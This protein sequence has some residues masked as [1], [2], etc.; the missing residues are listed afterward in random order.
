MIDSRKKFKKKLI[1]QKTKRN[2]L[3]FISQKRTPLKEDT[4]EEL[5]SN[6]ILRSDE[7]IT[8]YRGLLF[9][10]YQ[11]PH[12]K[13]ADTYYYKSDRP[14]SW[15]KDIKI[16]ER[17]AKYGYLNTNSSLI[18]SFI[19]SMRDGQIDGDLGLI[20]SYT[21]NPKDIL[22]DIE[23]IPNKFNTDY[24]YEKEVIVN[25]VSVETKVEKIFTKTATYNSYEEF[26]N[27]KVENNYN[28][29]VEYFKN[30]LKTIPKKEIIRRY[31]EYKEDVSVKYI[32]SLFNSDLKDFAKKTYAKY[33]ELNKNKPELKSPDF[34]ESDR[35]KNL[36]SDLKS[37]YR[38]V[39]EFDNVNDIIK[40]YYRRTLYAYQKELK[41]KDYDEDFLTNYRYYVHIMGH[42]YYRMV[43]LIS[44]IEELNV[45][46]PDQVKIDGRTIKI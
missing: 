23:K 44:I 39:R 4:I 42:S 2:L 34:S 14:T 25:A 18:A 31:N 11:A 17:F 27:R 22:V 8:L 26:K 12:I 46:K 41:M 32:K 15:T 6:P 40:P 10:E 38:Y 33:V 9:N 43:N 7:S 45:E 19:T 5:Q 35:V 36:Y 24:E 30:F 16:A 28:E 37:L 21:F 3:D 13:F 20:I 29:I 1:S